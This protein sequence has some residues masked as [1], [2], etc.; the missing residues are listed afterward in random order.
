MKLS[1]AIVSASLLGV[2]SATIQG[3]DI[4]NYQGSVDFASAY[5]SGARFVIIK[6]TEGT[7]YIDTGFSSHWTGATNAGFIR[8]GY[9]FA[10]PDSS[11]GAE[12]AKYFIKHGGNW[13][14]DGITLPGMLDIEYN[15]SGSTCY[16]LSASAMVNWIQDFVSTYH[17]TTGR[18]PMIYTTADW[19]NT[20]TGNSKAF[21]A[22][23]PLVLARYGS[24]PG[25]I[26]GGWEFQ[27][28]WQNSDSYTYGGD[29]DIWNGDLKGLQKMASG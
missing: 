15:P 5:K 22:N 28:I 1:A 29:S 17:S 25:T 13:S 6:A 27:S 16:G 8:G 12:Q 26:P 10:H 14:G 3:F 11:S 2:A 23:C 7:T 9:H 20:C 21:S 19:W 18:Y 24:S 4:S